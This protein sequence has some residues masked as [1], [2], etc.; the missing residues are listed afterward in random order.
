MTSRPTVGAVVV[1]GLLAGSTLTAQRGPVTPASKLPPEILSLACAPTALFAPPD[2]TLRITGGQ[3]SFYKDQYMP[4]DLLTISAGAKHGIQV[5]QEFYTKR[6]LILRKER[7]TNET[8]ATLM[9][10]GWI[11]V[12]AVDDEMSLATVTHACDGINVGDIL[13][14]F[15][16]P[17]MPSPPAI[18]YKAQRDNYGHVLTGN[19]RRTSFGKGDYLLIDRGSDHGVSPG[20]LFVLYR[21]KEVEGNF[22]YDL[23]EAMAV[24]VSPDKSTLLVTVSRDAIETGD[25]VAIRKPVSS[26]K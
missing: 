13:E 19:D 9:T 22:L 1:A 12:Y 16:L 20:S 10:T 6:V 18:R 4:G 8:P 26:S 15:V 23:G 5:G 3:D 21:N 25:L 17:T 7:V 24:S 2:N 14:P 11:R